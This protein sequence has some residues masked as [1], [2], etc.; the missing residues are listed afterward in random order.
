VFLLPKVKLAQVA[1]GV[2]LRLEVALFT[3]P[4]KALKGTINR[5][6]TMP[7]TPLTDT[8]SIKELVEMAAD[9]LVPDVERTASRI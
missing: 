4:G 7:D 6:L 8:A 1:G 2:Q 3:Y 9:R 5:K